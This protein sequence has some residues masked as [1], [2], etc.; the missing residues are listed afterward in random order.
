MRLSYSRSQG[1]AAP[2]GGSEAS[3]ETLI[4]HHAGIAIEEL[5]GGYG[6]SARARFGGHPGKTTNR[7]VNF[8][9]LRN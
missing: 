7:L 2:F 5:A 8:A 4:E 1:L 6:V 3:R 9:V